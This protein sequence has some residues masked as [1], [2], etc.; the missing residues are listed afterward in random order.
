MPPASPLSSGSAATW[1]ASPRPTPRPTTVYLI[2]ERS[3]QLRAFDVSV[4]G[5]P[6]RIA[7]WDF[8][9]WMPANHK[10]NKGLEGITFVPDAW[11]VESGFVDGEGNAWIES[12]GGLGGLMLASHQGNG[13]IFAFDLDI[14]GNGVTFVGEYTTGRTDSSGLEF[15]RVTGKLY[16]WHNIGDNYLEIVS[17]RS[18]P[19]D[20]DTRRFVS[21]SEYVGPRREGN[22][23]GI[24][25]TPA[26]GGAISTAEARWLFVTDDANHKDTALMWFREV[27]PAFDAER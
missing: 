16:I 4:N 10:R 13:H 1:R 27:D 25:I 5:S 11:L 8:S 2:N 18:E 19:V 20:E 17:L 21:L 12:S 24:A 7:T 22:L 26:G 23:E 9:K 15:D 6:Q 14:A 3:S